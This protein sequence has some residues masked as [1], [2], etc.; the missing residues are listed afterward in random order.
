VKLRHLHRLPCP[1]R[2]LQFQRFKAANRKRPKAS[3]NQRGLRLCSPGWHHYRRPE[4]QKFHR[5]IKAANRRRP[6]ASL[7]QRGLRL[8]SLGWH[9]YRR[10]ER[11]KLHRAIKA[12]N[13]RKPGANLNPQA[14]LLC[15]LR[16]PLNHRPQ[17]KLNR[18]PANRTED[19]RRQKKVDRR[20]PREPHLFRTGV[21]RRHNSWRQCVQI[22]AQ[23]RQLFVG[24]REG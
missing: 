11:R 10:P 3:L 18:L 9:H 14:L 8:C 16:W 5:A 21:A 1:L 2:R 23:F 15:S 4:R 12:A 20:V 24:A 6:K 7:D 22:R 17:S 13:R 19:R